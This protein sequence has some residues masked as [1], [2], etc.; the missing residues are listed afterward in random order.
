MRCYC[1]SSWVGGATRFSL[2]G[3][4]A[5]RSLMLSGGACRLFL[6]P[7]AGSGFLS[8]CN[9]VNC[10]RVRRVVAAEEYSYVSCKKG[11]RLIMA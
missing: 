8:N 11:G 7:G 2:V 9:R 5:G 3:C 4:R 1:G 10:K 6:S